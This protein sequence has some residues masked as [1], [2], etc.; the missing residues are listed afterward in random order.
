M[1]RPDLVATGSGA[2]VAQ[3]PVLAWERNHLHLPSNS[4]LVA[5]GSAIGR[6]S[7]RSAVFLDR[8][9]VLNEEICHITNPGQLTILQ[10]VCR[11][12]RELQGRFYL[13]VVTNQS[14]VARGLL[15]EEELLSI[16]TE[17]V[18]RLWLEGVVLDGLYYCPHHPQAGEQ[19]YRVT[20][21][22][23]KPQPGMLLR[24]QKD[25]GID[26]ERSFMVGDNP[27]DM[28]SALA[29]GV[30]GIMIADGDREPMEPVGSV[31]DLVVPNLVDAARIILGDGPGSDNGLTRAN[32]TTNLGNLGG[33]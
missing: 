33:A 15:N 32:S 29:A 3:P 1:S 28:E 10:E 16:H 6:P 19:A 20:C 27:S 13:L 2:E 30:R 12:L 9:G 8:D 7:T 23:R 25:W 11:G 5:E 17:L 21:D 31:P 24:A 14:A 26:L 4:R 22:C 18:R